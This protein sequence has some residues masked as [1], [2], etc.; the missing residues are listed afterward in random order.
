ML[1][2]VI[3]LRTR[4][5]YCNHYATERQNLRLC[6]TRLATPRSRYDHVLLSDRVL[7]LIIALIYRSALLGLSRPA[8]IGASATAPP[9]RVDSSSPSRAT[10]AYA[11]FALC[12]L[13]TGLG[14]ATP[15]SLCQLLHLKLACFVLNLRLVGF[16]RNVYPLWPMRVSVQQ[17]VRSLH[18]FMRYCTLA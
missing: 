9:T 5:C 10:A 14:V 16:L 2:P 7:Y 17:P 12:T 18:F 11:S 15:M 3:R 1:S 6:L 13:I 8:N 4:I